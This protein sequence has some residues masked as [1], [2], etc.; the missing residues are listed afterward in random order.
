MFKHFCSI[1]FIAL[2]QKC[3]L[4]G[5]DITGILFLDLRWR[6]HLNFADKWLGLFQVSKTLCQVVKS[7]FFE[8]RPP[9]VHHVRPLFF[10]SKVL[11]IK[12]LN[13]NRLLL[14]M[15]LIYSTL[16]PKM[17]VNVSL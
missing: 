14:Y 17:Y 12:K 13:N 8:P 2:F 1:W 3:E 9:R 4:S 10:I 5:R 11:E 7:F 16:K 15:R 6:A